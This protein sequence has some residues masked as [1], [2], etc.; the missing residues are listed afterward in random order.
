M[1]LLLHLENGSLEYRVQTSTPPLRCHRRNIGLL[2]QAQRGHRDIDETRV[3]NKEGNILLEHTAT[4]DSS[5][6]DELMEQH[7]QHGVQLR[8]CNIAVG[9]NGGARTLSR[10]MHMARSG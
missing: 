9:S 4:D 5:F 3:K 2:F 8:I 1:V 10:N 7:V 6:R